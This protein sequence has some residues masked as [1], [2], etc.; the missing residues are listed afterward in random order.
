MQFARAFVLLA[1][2]IIGSLAARAATLG[3][4][5]SLVGGASDLVLDE[6]RNQVYLIS[7]LQNQIQVYSLQRQNFQAP[8]TTDQTPLSAALSR[9]GRFL[10]V[11]C[12]DSSAL[13]V[14]DLDTQT[15]AGRVG[16]PARPEA[17][18]VAKD[19]RVLITTTGSGTGGAANTL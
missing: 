10:Y 7:P 4:S 17:V 13:D 18:A 16:L 12:Y 11:T 5:V 19:G 3:R 14:I 8:I 9:N 6:R 2:L 1:V 15:V